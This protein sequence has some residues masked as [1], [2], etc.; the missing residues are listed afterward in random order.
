MLPELQGSNHRKIYFGPTKSGYWFEC[1]RSDLLLLGCIVNAINS[2]AGLFAGIFQFETID[3]G[4]LKTCYSDS[5]D[6]ETSLL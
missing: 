3:I 6:N 2:Y 1:I 5:G 4:S